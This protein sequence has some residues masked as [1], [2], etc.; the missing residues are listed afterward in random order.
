M[1]DLFGSPEPTR[2]EQLERRVKELE[3][4]LSKANDAVVDLIDRSSDLYRETIRL[5]KKA[6]LPLPGNHERPAWYREEGWREKR[7]QG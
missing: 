2:E 6:G 4:Q 7:R 5:K 3:L 1:D